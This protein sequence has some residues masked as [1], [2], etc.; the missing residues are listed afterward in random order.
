MNSVMKINFSVLLFFMIATCLS[1]GYTVK[2]VYNYDEWEE[3]SGHHQYQCI[4]QEMCILNGGLLTIDGAQG[5]HDHG[6][7][8]ND[9]EEIHF[10]NAPNMWRFPK[11]LPSVFIN[12]ITIDVQNCNLPNITA[13]DLE[14]FK[15][16]KFIS[17]IRNKITTISSGTFKH[18]PNLEVIRLRHNLISFY[19]PDAFRVL[20]N[21]RVLDLRDNMCEQFDRK[22]KHNKIMTML[23]DYKN[24]N[25]KCKVR[26]FSSIECEDQ[27]ILIEH[28]IKK[29]NEQDLRIKILEENNESR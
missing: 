4:V 10:Y 18:N 23:D 12:L 2:C 19:E 25:F 11:I 7:T 22:A 8:N 13:E 1:M 17:L 28:L 3:D 27:T 16:L 24:K 5:H 14:P 6:K 21:L 20:N 29:V 9:V 15:K 26:K